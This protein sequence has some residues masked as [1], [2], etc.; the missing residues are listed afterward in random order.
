MAEYKGSPPIAGTIAFIFG[1]KAWYIYGASSNDYRN[2]MPNYALQW[3]MIE[4]A[5]KRLHNV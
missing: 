2:V 4:W 5:N 1:D 3:S